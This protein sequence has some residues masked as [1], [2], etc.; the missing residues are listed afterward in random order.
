[1][2]KHRM[3]VVVTTMLLLLLTAQIALAD[4][5]YIVAGGDTLFKIAQRF[6]VGQQEIATANAI[7]NPDW[8]YV[9]QALIIPDGS[10]AAVPAPSVA[11][12]PANAGA[13]TVRAGDTL[14]QI[15]ANYGV[16]PASL[17]AANGISNPSLIYVGQY[18]TIPNGNV[19]AP[20]VTVPA[21]VNASGEHWIDVNLSTQSLTAYEGTTAVFSTLISSGLPEFPTVTGQFRVWLRYQSQTMNGYSLG[22]DY[23]LENVPYVMYFYKDY[24]I[25]GTYWH[26][27]FG[28]QMSHGCVNVATSDAQWLF[29]WSTRGTLVNVHY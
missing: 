4:S 12:L 26:S 16:N 6:G 19:P 11:P 3:I 1:M 13:Y 28:Q 15:A 22:Y 29:N 14:S 18:L 7:T 5:S 24:A 9:G 20:I 17:A 2:K 10:A 8:I 27:N 25:H 23:Y 21:G